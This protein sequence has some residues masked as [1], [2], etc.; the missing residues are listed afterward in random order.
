MCRKRRN[1]TTKKAAIVVGRT[2]GRTGTGWKEGPK[3]QPPGNYAEV[4]TSKSKHVV[5]CTIDA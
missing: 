1:G 2:E 3:S 4:T 5:S